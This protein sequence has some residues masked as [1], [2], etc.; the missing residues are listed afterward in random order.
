M[1]NNNKFQTYFKAPIV[2]RFKRFSEGGQR[3][4]FKRIKK[5]LFSIITVVLNGEKNLE[6]TIKSVISQK[7]KD[8]EYIVLDGG[9]TDN[10]I[11]IIKNILNK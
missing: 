10:T 11:K 5:P 1:K 6:Q 2:K 4:S 9:S 3:L 8:F 7:I